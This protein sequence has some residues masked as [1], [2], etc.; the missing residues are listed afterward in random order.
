MRSLTFRPSLS[1]AAI[2]HKCRF[3]FFAAVFAV[4]LSTPL[5][6]T[7]KALKSSLEQA[8]VGRTIVSKV[9]IGG[10]A[11]P[12]G[13]QA[14][15]AVNTVITAEGQV[16]YRVEWG[17][18][19]T[20]VAPPEMTRRFRGGTS[21]RVV[22]IDLKDDRLELKLS[23]SS[24]DSAKVKLLLGADWQAKLGIEAVE[25]QLA[26][27]FT[28]EDGT[29]QS[30][31]LAESP[32]GIRNSGT[33][34][35]TTEY[36]RPSTA[37][38]IPGRIS[39]E[40]MQ[41][42]L[43]AAN[44]DQQQALSDLVTQTTRLSEALLSVLNQAS[45][46]PNFAS[47]PLIR[48]IAAFQHALGPA[49]RPKQVEDVVEMNQLL[50]HCQSIFGSF[51]PSDSSEISASVRQQIAIEEQRRE[52]IQ[53]VKL[54]I[55]AV[56]S[57]LDAGD[58]V[59]ANQAYRQVATDAPVPRFAQMYLQQTQSLGLD[60]S[61]YAEAVQFCHQHDVPLS[62]QLR[63]LAHEVSALHSSDER[64]LT[65]KYVQDALTDDSEA[66]RRQLASLPPFVFDQASYQVPRGL[67]D[68]EK[69]AFVSTHINSL[70]SSLATVSAIQPIAG[71]PDLMKT[72][73]EVVGGDQFSKLDAAAAQIVAAERV[74]A[75]LLS[76]Q[77]ALQTRIAAENEQRERRKAQAQEAE[78]ERLAEIERKKPVLLKYASQL[79]VIHGRRFR[80]PQGVSTEMLQHMLD[81]IPRQQFV[82]LIAMYKAM[83]GLDGSTTLQGLA[84]SRALFIGKY[85]MLQG[86]VFQIQADRDYP[87]DGLH[88]FAMFGQVNL[89]GNYYIPV[90]VVC[91]SRE[92][93]PPYRISPVLGKIIDFQL[94]TNR[95]GKSIIIPVVQVV[96]V[97]SP[98]NCCGDPDEIIVNEQ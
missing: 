78:Q 60:L 74:R 82:D 79:T 98:S 36:E 63:N 34:T 61:S 80:V 7:N 75:S 23:A 26:R 4:C 38:P 51:A 88:Q 37:P 53:K 35:P 20:D 94:G 10:R 18:L 22:G 40:Q 25:S 92:K 13:T 97:A 67:S 42:I 57:A 6:A 95:A 45:R 76:E 66:V 12:R 87:L 71:Q 46:Y 77:G 8:L 73:A 49:L 59:R 50:M 44:Q 70:D 43:A 3:M 62:Q 32:A 41:S 15:C 56:E 39:S 1:C 65:K 27:V 21:F 69:L 47:H 85:Y 93:V 58:F 48:E 30:R 2:S 11:T 19:R 9:M 55:I 54:S 33:A 28:F 31:Q 52:R 72:V 68:A 90:N 16:S 89:V 84:K 17:F 5:C 29:T 64:P 24:I 91:I 83:E 86:D 14:D 96:A 81:K